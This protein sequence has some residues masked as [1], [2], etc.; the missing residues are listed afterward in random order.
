MKKLTIC[1][2]LL[3]SF[4]LTSE[5]L[6]VEEIS[7]H[8]NKM[9]V[10]VNNTQILQDN[11]LY[12]DSLYLP[13]RSVSEALGASVSYN[14]IFGVVSIQSA[15]SSSEYEQLYRNFQILLYSKKISDNINSI[16]SLADITTIELYS[17]MNNDNGLSVM[18]TFDNVIEEAIVTYNKIYD[19]KLTE[20]YE[21]ASHLQTVAISLN[22]YGN[23]L[24]GLHFNGT[25]VKNA[26]TQRDIA[27]AKMYEA[28]LKALIC[29]DD[30]LLNISSI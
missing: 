5:V 28:K 10:F 18:E 12:N 21:V 7:V 22:D 6:A 26:T 8:K 14:D 2:S 17:S 30:I 16:V 4:L 23:I 24:T 9:Q 27:F 15:P 29:I 11:F 13:L 19:L 3:F 25:T 20:L 1:I